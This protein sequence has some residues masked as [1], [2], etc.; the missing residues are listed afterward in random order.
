MIT[1]TSNIVISWGNSII[2]EIACFSPRNHYQTQKT[3]IKYT[4]ASPITYCLQ[5]TEIKWNIGEEIKHSMDVKT[6]DDIYIVKQPARGDNDFLKKFAE[7]QKG[8]RRP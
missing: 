3:A 2:P 1:F 5:H 8:Y 4:Q 6:L 7:G